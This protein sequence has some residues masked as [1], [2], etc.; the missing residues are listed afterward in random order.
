MNKIQIVFEVKS[1][2]CQTISCS[3]YGVDPAKVSCEPVV[4]VVGCSRR[5]RP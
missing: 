2:N 5:S 1:I 4:I 3:G